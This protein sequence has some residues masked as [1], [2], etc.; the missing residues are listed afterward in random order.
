[1]TEQHMIR[2]IVSAALA[3]IATPSAAVAE[4]LSPISV[5][6]GSTTAPSKNGT[7]Q[8]INISVQSWKMSG[9]K[10]VTHEIPLH[11][12][13]IAHLRGGSILTTIGGQTSERKPGDYWAVNGETAMRVNVLGE[14]AVM[15]TIVVSN[16]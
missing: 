3:V 12:F 5:F 7:E 4:M 9:S 6:E 2:V 13:Y 11:G 14:R 10:N 8:P 16:K 1:M 15:E